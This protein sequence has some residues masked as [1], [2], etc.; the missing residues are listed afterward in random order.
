M[1]ARPS[2]NTTNDE[3]LDAV[4]G[5]VGRLSTRLGVAIYDERRRRGWSLRTLAT[6]AGVAIGTIHAIENGAGASIEMY[7]RLS[8][9]FGRE[10]EATIV[11]SARRVLP[12]DD[13]DLVHAA[14]GEAEVTDLRTR[15]F[16]VRVDEP[17]QHYHFAGR[18]DVLAW[19]LARSA[20]MHIEN[21][22][23]YPDVQDSTGRFNTKRSYLATALWQSLGFDRPPRTETHV[24][25]ALWSAEVLRVL[26]R[27]PSTFRATCP[28]PPD[29][30]YA[31]LA[32]EPPT[33]RRSTTLVLF[34]PFA[35][36]RQRRFLSLDSALD[37]ARSRIAGYAEAAAKLRSLR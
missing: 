14:M 32:G 18:A 5:A 36:G 33:G 6:K 29:D 35:T 3:P 16:V 11:E 1:P 4:T 13:T 10:L 7:V 21:R 34:D 28:D 19:D 31:W 8:K 15:G 25:V 22:T 12:R 26:R 9:A 17:W 37:G 30:F 2:R 23:R 20:L 24:M 27:D